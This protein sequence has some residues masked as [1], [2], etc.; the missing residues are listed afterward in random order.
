MH[1]E[2]NESMLHNLFFIWENIWK[3]CF[4]YI[5]I[6]FFWRCTWGSCWKL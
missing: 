6:L 2:G 3:T 4:I 1:L 5:S